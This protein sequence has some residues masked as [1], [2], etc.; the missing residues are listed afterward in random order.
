MDLMNRACRSIVTLAAL[1]VATSFAGTAR[2]D[3]L[4]DARAAFAAGDFDRA[5]AAY[6]KAAAQ[7]YAE[8]RAGIGMVHLRRRQY[9]KAQEQFELAQRMDGNLAMAWYGQ[10]EV[11]R[12]Q[13]DCANAVAKLQRAVELDRKYPE[14]QLALGDCL[15]KSGKHSDAVRVLEQGTNW[16]PKVRPRF[17]I[18]LGDAELARDSLRDAGIFYTKAQQEAP[19]DPATNRALG[20]FY[21]KRGIGALAVQNLERAVQLDS[22]DVELRFALGQAFYFAQRYNEALE[23]YRIVAERDPEFAPGQYALGHLYYLSG[24]AD[25]RRYADARPYLEKYT[26]MMPQD[27]KGWSALGRDLYFLKERDA[28]AAALIKAEGL[29]DKSKEMYR[30]LARTYVDKREWPAALAAYGKADLETT[31]LFRIAQVHAILGDIAKADSVYA[32]MVEKDPTSGE[33]RAALVEWGKLKYRQKDHAAAVATFQKRNA[34]DPPSDE[35]FYYTGLAHLELKQPSEAIAAL[36]RATEI[37][38]EKG[39]RQF[40]LAMSLLRADST[41]AA[42]SV[43]RRSVE[44]DSTSKN[45]ALAFQQ[46]GYRQLLRKDWSEA[47]TTLEKAVAIDATSVQSLVWLAQAYQNSGNRTKASENYRKVL[48]IQPGQPDAVKGLK[49][50]GE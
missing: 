26:Q 42:E 44:L 35:A 41:D 22:S 49:L 25:P 39:D 7:G 50:L 30:I 6:E 40:W 45:A 32:Q 10:G 43:F 24:Q 33:A 47:I 16:G 14:A 48:G 37:A 21:V 20:E 5:V 27:A 13:G 12:R 17:L 23:Q 4:K 31:D 1:V 15:V 3:D 28:A 38:P 11:L 18:A 19:D 34:L 29:G 9:D 2:A 46:L 36:R 8:G